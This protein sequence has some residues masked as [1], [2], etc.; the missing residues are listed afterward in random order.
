VAGDGFR[1]VAGVVRSLPDEIRMQLT[2]AS[3]ET[4]DDVTLQIGDAKVVWGSAEDSGLKADVLDDL[5]RAAPPGSVSLYD[6]SA[7]MNPVTM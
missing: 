7:P 4:A 6:V 5:M 3:A 2:A 1:A